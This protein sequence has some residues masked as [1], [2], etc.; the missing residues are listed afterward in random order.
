[1]DKICETCKWW[2]H[3]PDKE[4]WNHKHLTKLGIGN[5]KNPALVDIDSKGYESVPEDG[6]GL[7]YPVC[8]LVTGPKFG[9]LK[10]EPSTE[11]TENA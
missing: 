6:F 8:D 9:C 5:C 4:D 2:R 7:D 1:M 10:W 11:R 3:E